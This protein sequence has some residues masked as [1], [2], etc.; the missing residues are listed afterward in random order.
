MPLTAKYLTHLIVIWTDIGEVT[1]LCSNAKHMYTCT[2][3]AVVA[4]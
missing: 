1:S 3:V 4:S 2:D